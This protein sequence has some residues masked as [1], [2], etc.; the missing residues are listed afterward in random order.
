MTPLTI[1]TLTLATFA[2]GLYLGYR[3]GSHDAPINAEQQALRTQRIIRFAAPYI[4][5][6]APK[7]GWTIIRDSKGRIIDI[8]GPPIRCR[9]PGALQDLLGARRHRDGRP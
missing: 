6:D 4:E 7:K 3:W 5:V 8:E 1:A 2:L 9:T